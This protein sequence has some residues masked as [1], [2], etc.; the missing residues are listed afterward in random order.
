MLIQNVETIS[1]SNGY[2]SL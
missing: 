1:N 2:S